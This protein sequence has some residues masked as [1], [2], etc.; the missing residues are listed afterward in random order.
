MKWKSCEKYKNQ[1]FFARVYHNILFSR[2]TLTQNSKEGAI[3]PNPTPFPAHQKSHATPLY[4]RGLK[5]I[6]KH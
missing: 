1:P 5:T 2:Y 3:A 4:C 6:K